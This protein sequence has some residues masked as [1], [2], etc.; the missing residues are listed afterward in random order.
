MNELPP[1]ASSLETSGVHTDD[2]RIAD[3]L[4]P[5]IQSARTL[6][7][8]TDV[9]GRFQWWCQRAGISSVLAATEADARRFQ[10][11]LARG[12]VPSAAAAKAQTSDERQGQRMTPLSP[13]TVD[14]Y[15]GIVQTFFDHLMRQGQLSS[16]PFYWLPRVSIGDASARGSRK[17]KVLDDVGSAAL[18]DTVATWPTHTARHNG[19]FQQARWIVSLAT[20]CALSPAQVA[21]EPMSSFQ[22]VSNRWYI[23]IASVGGFT[24]RVWVDDSVVQALAQ[25]RTWA[26]SFVGLA[27]IST[28]PSCGEEPRIP[29]VGSASDPRLPVT[30]HRV[31]VVLRSVVTETIDRLEQAGDTTLAQSLEAFK[32]HRTTTDDV[33]REIAQEQR[34]AGDIVAMTKRFHWVQDCP[35]GPIYIPR[36]GQEN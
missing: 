13:L 4:G 23:D 18:L 35:P 7:A 34:A 1:K 9:L 31:R 26:R 21:S 3:Y 32:Q 17:V 25:Y 11:D 28:L 12:A 33:A 19:I 30:A 16:N 36:A 20:K 15:V 27:K 2:D 22:Q 10:A 24:K 5:H 14:Y 6:T 29:L 8:Y